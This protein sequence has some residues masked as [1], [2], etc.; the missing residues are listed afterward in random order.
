MAFVQRDDVVEQVAAAA[1]Y[2]TL[3]D[4]VLPGALDRGLHASNSH[5]ANGGGNFQPVFL[6]MIEEQELGSGLVGECF[7]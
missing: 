7:P 2:P 6:V 1:S 5:G 4:S 3:G